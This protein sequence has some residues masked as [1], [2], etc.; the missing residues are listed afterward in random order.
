MKR[1]LRFTWPSQAQTSS[2]KLSA[3]LLQFA[4]AVN[5]DYLPVCLCFQLFFF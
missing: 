4:E 3:S 2:L 1:D 5:P